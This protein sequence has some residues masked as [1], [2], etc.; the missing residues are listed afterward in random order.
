VAVAR[1]IR[2]RRAL[3]LVAVIA[4]AGVLL[5][6]CLSLRLA[7]GNGKSLIE[8]LVVFFGYFTVLSNVFVAL[9]SSLPLAFRSTRLGRWF[10]TGVVLGCATT[11]ILAVGIGY[12]FLLRDAWA[13]RGLQ[14]IADVIL[15]YAVPVALF[16]Y[17]IR[18]PPKQK[19]PVWTPLAWCVYPILYCVY[20]LARGE[21]IGSYPY[22]FI[23]VPSLGYSQ[24]L[25][26]SF[27]LLVLFMV[28]GGLVYGT[29]RFRNRTPVVAVH[30]RA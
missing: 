5:Q 10:G 3:A 27:G 9:A 2:R 1:N 30:A 28:I 25:I 7:L 6:L 23:D 12:H 16:A 13:P 14:W 29:A 15:H 19:L 8:G 24:V 18:F 22:H 21:L 4:W 20:A 17:W 11:A 26:N